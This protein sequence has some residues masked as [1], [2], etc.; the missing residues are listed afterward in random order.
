M[1][2][3]G[4]A[5][6]GQENHA[7]Q[8]PPA[9]AAALETRP[10]VDE[11][12]RQLI[13]AMPLVVWVTDS[14]GR[15]QLFNQL[16]RDYTGLA[17]DHET[18]AAVAADVIHPDDRAITMERFEQA[19]QT[20]GMFLVEH[21]VRDRH[22]EYRW[23][24]A[25][26]TPFRDPAS[27]AI[28]RWLG[29][30]TD[31]H[32]RKQEEEGRRQ[33]AARQSFQLALADR[34]RPLLDPAE[35]MTS[36]C[37]L[38]GR[39][40]G[41]TRVTYGELEN[42]GAV[43]AMNGNWTDGS[44]PSLA[45]LRLTIDDFG[46]SVGAALRAGEIVVVADVTAEERLA[47]F[48]DQYAAS[49]IGSYMGIPL[50]KRGVLQAILSVHD[51]AAHAWT[52]N[53]V[54]MARDM[55]DRTWA[56]VDSARAQLA[57]RENASRVQLALAAGAIIGTWFWNVPNDRFTVDEAFA[58]AFGL[59]P[60]LGRAG[61][62]LAQV[63]ATV[64]PDDLAG[65]TAA[66][67]QAIERG[68]QFA[69]QYRVRRADGRYYWLEANGRVERDAAG[70]ALAFPGVLLDVEGR[71][72]V[73]A[74]RDRALQTLRVLNADL[75][76]KV[77]EQLL[78][79][80]RT[81]QVSPDILAVLNADGYV[82]ASN[83]A[84]KATLGWTA[85][86]LASAPLL[87]FVHPDDRA[88]AR[89][90]WRMATG[91]DAPALRFEHRYRCKDGGWRWLSW[92]VVPDEGKLYCSARDVTLDRR[93][94]AELI[95]RTEERDRM[96]NTS[97]DLMLLI[98]FDG[99]LRRVNPAWTRL[100]GYTAD[101]LVGRH[102][103]AFVLPEDHTSTV[104]AYVAAAGGGTPQI[105]NRYRHK[106]GSLRWIAWVAAPFGDTTYATGRDI[107]LER[108]RQAALEQAQDQLRQSQKMEAVG[109]LTGGLAH[110]FNNL[111][112]T[113]MGGLELSAIRIRQDR[114]DEVERYMGMAMGATRR[115]AALTHRLLAFS[116]R[117]TLAPVATDVNALVNGMLEMIRRTVGP[118]VQ[119]DVESTTP[120]W[121]VLADP[122]Q[123]ENSLLNL[124]LN[125]RDAMPDGGRIVI[126]TGNRHVDRAS[127][128][129]HGIDAGEYLALC[130]TD[131]GTGM[132]PEVMAKAFEPFFTTK[133]LGQGTGLGL[134]MIYGFARQ[135]GGHASIASQVGKGSE[136]CMLLPRH[137]GNAIPAAAAQAPSLEPA[138]GTGRT[139]LVVDD[140]PDVRQL[141]VDVLR[142]LGHVAIEAADG[143]AGL[144]V[145]QS[146]ARI[147]LLISDVGLPGPMNGRQMADAGRTGR[148][149][150]KVLFITGY[151]EATLLNNGQL[152]A[153][154]AVLSKPFPLEV[155]AARVREMAG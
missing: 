17:F 78:A 113:I 2:P 44:V 21:R 1:H 3:E 151:A 69:H 124:C 74:E 15:V 88:G 149:G 4:N 135:S 68:G 142:E 81:W 139:V 8:S 51:S 5:T 73:E 96:W 60:A 84:W 18:A 79:R 145:L 105:V 91:H 45:G 33:F 72:A 130:V 43:I 82:E 110:D 71:R 99:Y 119:V 66:V 148:P 34:I 31:I 150:L 70:N 114:P 86:D 12:L 22:G 106:D 137:H 76:R 87:D 152:E 56:A 112:A 58:H 133:P 93:A 61:L 120:L 108:E 103:N 23:L 40:L 97:P 147:D 77:T 83:P 41:A 55:V 116:R 64:H 102:V 155:L 94:Q 143:P 32:D 117:Q 47:S 121:T 19:L 53:D 42:A 144:R 118:G 140:E 46:P 48:R 129:A 154:M 30:S 98:D 7:G 100:L 92:V 9:T 126:K 95:T 141:V 25:R 62:R 123:L 16:W 39:L 136:V 50:M 131:T 132:T 111:L 14:V 125:A 101:E 49:G 57:A 90:E 20:G 138:A 38:L 153:G 11:E 28:T 80:G 63:V 134:S 10:W 24:V 37:E 146:D 13:D 127:A 54:D 89:D 115:A 59:D 52:G 75:E 104:D 107:T 128:A 26:A 35:V 27:G 36:A 109:Q 67:R 29:V 65:L 122:S 85:E 6:A